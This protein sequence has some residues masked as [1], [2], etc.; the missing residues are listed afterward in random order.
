MRTFS[1]GLA[2]IDSK[3]CEILRLRTDLLKLL[4]GLNLERETTHFAFGEVHF[5]EMSMGFRLPQH[6]TVSVDWNARQLRNEHRDSEFRVFNVEATEKRGKPKDTGQTPKGDFVAKPQLTSRFCTAP[7][8]ADAVR[9]PR[10]PCQP[11][12]GVTF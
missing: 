3:S 2:Y 6:V 7:W 1:Q 4:P 10:S 11:E 5:R 12:S 9:R 8:T